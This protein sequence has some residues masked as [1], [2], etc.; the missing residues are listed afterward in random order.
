MENM[1]FKRAIS[2]IFAVAMALG[3]SSIGFAQSTVTEN[4]ADSQSPVSTTK[5]E[6]E[7]VVALSPAK[8]APPEENVTSPASKVPVKQSSTGKEWEF[9]VAPY[10]FLSGISGTVGADG[11]TLPI[12]LSV[13]DVLSHFKAGFMGTFEA[14]RGRLVIVNDLIWVKLTQENVTPGSLY[15]TSKVSVNMTI[16]NPS[17]GVRVAESKVGSLDIL[18]GLRV[19]SVKNT[20][21]ATSGILPSFSVSARKT[22][23][24]PVVGGH[25]LMNLSPK[26]YLST[27]FDIGRGFGTHVTG[28]AYGGLGYRVNPKVSLVGGYRYLK[29]D[30]SDDSG[31]VYDTSMQGLIMGAKFAF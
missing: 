18:G 14:R 15:D 11:R 24:A 21:S 7:Q 27:I 9:A 22:W 23:A 31:F 5:L 25:G 4:K 10:L 8:K 3:F 13:G 12:D 1:N 26:I 29:N 28:Q 17:A 16:Y 6:T 2:T 30:Y 19:T 20:L